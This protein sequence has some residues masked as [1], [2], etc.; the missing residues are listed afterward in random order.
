[1][2]WWTGWNRRTWVEDLEHYNSGGGYSDHYVS[3][4]KTLT[5]GTMLPR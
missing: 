4:P 5:I 2:M 3:K 1:M